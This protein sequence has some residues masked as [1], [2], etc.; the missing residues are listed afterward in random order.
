MH[1]IKFTQN[2]DFVLKLKLQFKVYNYYLLAVF[3][4][5]SSSRW[6]AESL[7]HIHSHTHTHTHL[8]VGHSVPQ[9]Q[10]EQG[11]HPITPKRHLLESNLLIPD[12]KEQIHT[13]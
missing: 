6:T 3:T 5:E 13:L 8:W 9:H 12:K 4:V 1:N 11:K 7:L 2:K 10:V